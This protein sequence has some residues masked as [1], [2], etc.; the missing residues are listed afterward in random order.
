[1]AWMRLPSPACSD[2]KQSLPVLRR[3][4]TRPAS[5]DDVAGGG[6]G[7][8]VGRTRA[9]TAG[10]SCVIGTRDRVGARRRLGDQPL[11]LGE[12]HGL[13]LGDLVSVSS[14]SVAFGQ[15]GVSAVPTAVVCRMAIVQSCA[16]QFRVDGARC[17]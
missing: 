6:V 14:G 8:E 7:L 4:T 13:L 12:A 9:R 17:R 10:S 16:A 15:R 1:M 3:C 11:A 5:A 2:A